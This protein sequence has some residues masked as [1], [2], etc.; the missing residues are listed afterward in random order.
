MAYRMLGRTGMMVSEVVC[1][2][3][4]IRLDNYE[5]L[6]LALEMGLNYLDMAPAYGR[7]ECEQAYGKFLGGSAKREKVFLSTKVSG[8]S[9]LRNRL[10][11]EIYDG[12]PGG[13]TESARRTRRA[14]DRRAARRPAGLLV[15]VLPRH[16]EP[17]R[18]VLPQQRDDAGLRP[19]G[20][21]LGAFSRPCPDLRSR[22]A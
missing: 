11:K 22:A 19:Q 1:G 3:D 20:R 10:Y 15:R 17:V 16:E 18:A 21:R 8:F 4:P 12:L 14:H 2:G 6:N 5:H 7:G 13:Q 9:E